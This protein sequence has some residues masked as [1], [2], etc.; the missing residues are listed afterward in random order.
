MTRNENIF[1]HFNLALSKPSIIRD[2]P[3]IV[4]ARLFQ[5]GM[6][7]HLHGGK[8]LAHEKPPLWLKCVLKATL[9]GKNPKVIQSTIEKSFLKKR[10]NITNTR[11]LQNCVELTEAETFRRTE[12]ESR[13]I[14]LLFMGRISVEKGIES[15][16]LAL[17]HLE[18]TGSN[19]NL[20]WLARSTRQTIYSKFKHCWEAEYR[21][22]VGR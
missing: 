14:N 16:F 7:V 6:I 12:L 17:E 19:S 5:R 1:V 22:F 10:Y 8:Y 3:L 21:G 15:I 18:R 11:V 9:S 13:A 2:A 20:L 4:L